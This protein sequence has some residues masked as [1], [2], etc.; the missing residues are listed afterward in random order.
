[1]PHRLLCGCV[2]GQGQASSLCLLPAGAWQPPCIPGDGTACCISVVAFPKGVWDFQQ[3]A[4]NP[5][6]GLG[7]SVIMVTEVSVKWP[8]PCGSVRLHVGCEGIC[9][10]ATAGAA[11]PRRAAGP[12]LGDGNSFGG[13]TC[14][15][16]LPLSR[17]VTFSRLGTERLS[18]PTSQTQ[19]PAYIHCK[20]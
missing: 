4:P 2:R 9:P 13:W 8:V 16:T 12:V 18:Y 10:V 1:M 17:Y 19:F 6:Q 20:L 14:I 5:T 7:D 11:R 15:V 3:A